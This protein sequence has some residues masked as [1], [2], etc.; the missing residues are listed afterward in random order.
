M[1]HGSLLDK[2]GVL[3]ALLAA[4]L[5]GLVPASAVSATVV[6]GLAIE[7]RAAVS[8]GME[9]SQQDDP[10]LDDLDRQRSFG[11]VAAS[12]LAFVLLLHV[13]WLMAEVDRAPAQDQVA[14]ADPRPVRPEASAPHTAVYRLQEDGGWLA[15]TEPIGCVAR[16]RTLLEARRGVVDQVA[17]HLGVPVE[18]VSLLDDVELPA[19]AARAVEAARSGARSREQVAAVLVVRLGVDVRDAGALLGVPHQKV[20]EV[21]AA[22]GWLP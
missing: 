15:E 19:T 3:A 9:R 4:L 14:E 16:G 1:D 6:P 12:L 8:A 22:A 10:A 20:H 21:L 5:V 18:Q 11:F 17:G 2:A 13:R 7:E